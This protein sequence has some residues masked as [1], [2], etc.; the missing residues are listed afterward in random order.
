VKNLTNQNSVKIMPTNP[1]D[2]L[3]AMKDKN[4]AS[5]YTKW[6]N[7]EIQEAIDDTSSAI[8]HEQ[9]MRQIRETLKQACGWSI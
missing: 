2:P 4:Q 1:I 9:A 8:P 6:L 7:A 5:A 3:P